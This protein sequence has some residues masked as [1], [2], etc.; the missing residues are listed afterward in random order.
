MSS[1]TA[2][3]PEIAAATELGQ[4]LY[5]TWV[6][7]SES[8][9]R[10]AFDAQRA[11]IEAGLGL[12]DLSVKGNRQAVEQLSEIVRRT[13]QVALESWQTTVTAGEKLATAANAN[14]AKR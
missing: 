5:G 2:H 8:A 3:T 9:I 11:A 7:E 1:T 6:S 13:Q 14:G 12:F 10:A 4:R